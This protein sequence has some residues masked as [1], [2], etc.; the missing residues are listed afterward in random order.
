M[1]D[2]DPTSKILQIITKTVK[3]KN[4]VFVVFFFY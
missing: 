3:N 1:N 4:T 2:L